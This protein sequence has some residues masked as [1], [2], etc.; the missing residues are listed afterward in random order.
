MGASNTYLRALVGSR[1]DLII[2][3]NWISKQGQSEIAE[4]YRA[5]ERTCG[6][7]EGVELIGLY[8]PLNETW[9]WSQ[10]IKIDALDKWRIVDKEI[11]RLYP[12]LDNV[13]TQ[14][15]S[16]LY[17]GWDTER[18]PPHIMDMASMRYLVFDLGICREIKAIRE[19]YFQRCEQFEGL[20]GAGIIGMY[21]PITEIWNWALIKVFDSL[22]RFSDVGTEYNRTYRPIQEIISI[23]QR[24][25]ERYNP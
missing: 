19:Y 25:Y 16:R 23:I 9:N 14:S 20:D 11:Q 1:M 18:R 6:S 13:V 7:I 5:L 4:Y 8:K 17:W 21:N 22:T 2:E 10:L 12:D 24:V 15:M 3:T